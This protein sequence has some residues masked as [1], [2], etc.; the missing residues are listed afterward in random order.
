VHSAQ[1]KM[2][3]SGVPGPPLPESVAK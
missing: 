2:P 3:E 1:R